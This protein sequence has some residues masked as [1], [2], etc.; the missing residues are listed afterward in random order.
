MPSHDFSI[1][2]LGKASIP[3]PVALSKRNDDLIANYV[4]DDELIVYDVQA[5]PG[6]SVTYKREELIE[7]AGPREFIYFDPSKVR[8]GIIT[9]G[10]LCPGLNDVIRAIV[11][12][13][14]HQYGVRSIA[15]IR[16]GYRGLLPQWGYETIDLDHATVSEIHRQGGT[17]LGSSRGGG[18]K[19]EELVDSIERMNLSLFFTI[20]G[21]GT[22]RGACRI[23]EEIERRKLK[24]AVIGIP[25]T[26]DNDLSFIQKSFGFETAVGKAVEAVA[27]AHVEA[28]DAV[29]G[30]GMVKLMGR[31]SGF[32][33]AQVV[34]QMRTRRANER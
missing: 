14:W 9:C 15:G 3:S 7:K 22:Q 13:L 33:A 24:T 10:G 27:G 12:T 19:T 2:S 23:A 4:S 30:I 26:I 18:E 29:N 5:I 34:P 32:I 16:F 17:I 8:A 1:T 25:K 6:Q 20:G 11:M 31:E 21:D 28:H